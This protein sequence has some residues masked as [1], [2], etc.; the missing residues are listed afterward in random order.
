[1]VLYA[2]KGMPATPA[3]AQSMQPQ[4]KKSSVSLLYM[5][6]PY[7]SAIGCYY[8]CI[9]NLQTSRLT[10]A[11]PHLSFKY[12]VRTC[13]YLHCSSLV[14]CVCIC[15]CVFVFISVSCAH[16]PA[17]RVVRFSPSVHGASLLRNNIGFCA[18]APTHRRPLSAAETSDTLA[19]LQRPQR[20]LA[21][22]TF[23][24]LV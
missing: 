2:V 19:R 10:S 20:A 3:A 6:I 12:P 14:K 15:T 18:W 21:F 22:F 16:Q 1:M 4:S 5:I 13:P 24:H 8:G 7:L 11:L 17:G 9:S 23:S